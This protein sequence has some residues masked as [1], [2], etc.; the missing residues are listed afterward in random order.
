MLIVSNNENYIV[1]GEGGI[2]RIV[3]NVNNSV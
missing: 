2:A 1:V 3:S